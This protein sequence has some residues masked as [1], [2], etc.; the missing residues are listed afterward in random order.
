M[1]RYFFIIFILSISLYMIVSF[2]NSSVTHYEK[3]NY[4][5]KARYNISQNDIAAFVYRWFASFDHQLDRRYLL[6]FLSNNINISYP[7]FTINSLDD[8]NKWY[9]NVIANINFNSHTIS[10]L[11][12]ENTQPNNWIVD[13]DILWNAKT[14][15][16]EKIS[17]NIHQSWLL[18]VVKKKQKNIII[19]QS[20]K[21]FINK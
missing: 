19:V 11:K 18:N 7:D 14:Y 21:T 5:S 20:I 13:F 4:D 3:S 8:F 6:P 15:A 9:D 2:K 16:N 12:I 1:K 10:N 17:Q